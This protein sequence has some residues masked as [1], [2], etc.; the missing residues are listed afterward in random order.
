MKP[1]KMDVGCRNDVI[2]R[3]GHA[4]SNP[5]SYFPHNRRCVVLK[6]VRLFAVKNSMKRQAARSP[7]R[8]IGSVGDLGLS[9]RIVRAIH[10]GGIEG[11]KNGP[12]CPQ[13]VE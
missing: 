2:R 13:F 3:A 9:D 10:S 8:A 1:R 4:S 11:T 5:T 7:A 6:S 12:A